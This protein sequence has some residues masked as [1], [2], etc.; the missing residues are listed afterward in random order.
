MR[1]LI[2]GELRYA[3]QS[4]MLGEAE[5]TDLLPGDSYWISEAVLW[6]SDWDHVGELTASL[7]SNLLLISPECIL[8]WSLLFPASH[9]FL[10]TY[11]QDFVKF[12]R[13]LP[14]EELTDVLE[15][16]IVSHLANNHGRCKIS[17]QLFR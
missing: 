4:G 5:E 7:E 16:A 14:Q 15:P 12:Y 3:K 6:M 11:A 9:K 8:P 13:N 1:Y 17:A 2:S 10:K